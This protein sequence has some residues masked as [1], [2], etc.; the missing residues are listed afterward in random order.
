MN[1]IIEETGP[2]WSPKQKPMV[3]GG[4]HDCGKDPHKMPQ[5]IGV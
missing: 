4:I 1:T 2:K 3:Q 5:R